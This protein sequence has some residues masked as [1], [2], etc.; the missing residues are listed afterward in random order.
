[1]RRIVSL[2]IVLTVVWIACAGA[3]GGPQVPTHNGY[4]PKEAKPWKKPKTLKLDDKLEAKADGDVSYPDMRR[5]RWFQL[6]LPSSGQLVL[7]LEITPPGDAV[8]DD[9]DL[10]LEVLDPSYHVISK[11]DL[12]DE[13]AH[14]LNKKKT[15]VDLAA[16]KYLIH[17]YL[18]GRMD[19]ADF[20][21]RASF[22]PTASAEARTNFPADVAF[23][24]PLAVVP[25]QDDTPAGFRPTTVS[26][27]TVTRKPKTTVPKPPPT[28]AA[29]P[30]SAR[31]IAIQVVPEGTRI[32]VGRGTSSLAHDG[33]HATLSGISGSFPIGNCNER[34]CTALIKS[35]TPD[36]I[37]GANGTVMLTP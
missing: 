22:K 15:L 20:A 14:E 8:N 30:V 9:F 31:I 26:K 2:P 7:A 4:K 12:E 10:A 11:S 13:D 6:D 34:T 16:G 29:E 35:A 28:P 17:V 23:V 1:M 33:M 37:K 24:P 27:V 18:Q 36:Q 19:S 32:T 25:I 21:L 3:C 5:A